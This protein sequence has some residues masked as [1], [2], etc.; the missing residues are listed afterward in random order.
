MKAGLISPSVQKSIRGIEKLA[1]RKRGITRAEAMKKL[2]L[3][4]QQWYHAV[5][6][7]KVKQVGLKRATVYFKK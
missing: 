2:G 5:G 4:Q 3:T 1:A 7:A 6:K